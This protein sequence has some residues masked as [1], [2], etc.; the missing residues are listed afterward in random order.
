MRRC[1]FP[2]GSEDQQSRGLSR[3]FDARPATPGTVGN[4][5]CFVIDAGD[6]GELCGFAEVMIRSH[7]EG[8]WDYTDAGQ[9][10]V[11]YLEAWWVDEPARGAGVGRE[12]VGA[13]ENWARAQGSLVL[14]SDALLD[15]QASHAA[16]AA[17]G[18]SEVERAVH[19]VKKLE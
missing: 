9:L 13:C 4:Q 14:A 5:A 3:Y 6:G 10:G 2:D 11:A 19:F 1:L 15:N 7:A 8:C 12:L 17:L 16:H 18:F